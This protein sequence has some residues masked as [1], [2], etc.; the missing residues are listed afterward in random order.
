M[1]LI[2]P[3]HVLR[4]KEFSQKGFRSKAFPASLTGASL[5]LWCVFQKA[6]VLQ[7][8]IQTGGMGRWSPIPPCS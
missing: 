4:P 7:V 2:T 6:N 3:I 1:I 8:L 5:H